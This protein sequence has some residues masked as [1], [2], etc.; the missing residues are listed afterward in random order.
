MLRIKYTRLFAPIGKPVAATIET[1]LL[2]VLM[3]AIGVW[4]NPLDPLFIRTQFAWTWLAPLLLALRYGPLPGL[5]GALVVFV[6]WYAFEGINLGAHDLPKIY[7]LGGLIVVM[8]AGEFSSIWR[9]RVRRAEATQEYLDSRLDS[10]TQTH[11][12]LRL[13]HD[14]LEQ[15][16]LSRPVSMRDALAKLRELAAGAVAG[17][18][19]L[20][21]A[22]AFLKLC[23]QFCQI[24]RA[25]LLPLDGRALRTT[26]AV[27]LG[28]PFELVES[29]A[30]IRHALDEGMLS[31][32]AGLAGQSRTDSRY[33]IA[34]P[35]GDVDRNLHGILIVEALPFF[36]LQEET[37]QVLNLMLGYYADTLGAATLIAPLQAEWPACPVA[38]ALELQRLTHLRQT[39]RVPSSLVSLEFVPGKAAEDLPAAIL[40][41]QRSLDVT[42]LI[43]EDAAQPRAL[44][45][46]LPLAHA[47]GVEGYLTRIERWLQ[48]QQGT[49]WEGAGIRYRIWRIGEEA[50]LALMA[51][52]L[53][54]SHVA[55]LARARRT[56]A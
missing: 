4:F 8:L 3:L 5:G 37:L 19:S 46:I 53:E 14:R 9:A 56:A 11:Y 29:D 22:D 38:F 16:L 7:F 41:Q 34:A 36:A 44:L 31:H 32:V 54:A 27:F 47:S 6:G 15:E 21:G 33:L 20:P 17:Q 49:D 43:G 25:A 48:T 1:L 26:A 2:P 52:V 13:S 28:A 40:R 12:L 24:E 51:R 35:L 55:D 18:G 30:L 42:W 50:S 39:A 10:L 45:A 23:S